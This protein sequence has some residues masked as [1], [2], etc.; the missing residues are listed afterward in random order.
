[1]IDASLNEVES[2]AA[3]AA[4]GA[5]LPWG[6]AEET[7]RAA[8]W[9][10]ACDE[11]WA[12]S[13]FDLLSRHMTFGHPIA[14]AG[15]LTSATA[16]LPMSPL[17]LGP[18][19]ADRGPCDQPLQLSLVAHPAWLLPFAGQV[20]AAGGTAIEILIARPTKAPVV[21]IAWPHAVEVTHEPWRALDDA[22]VVMWAPVRPSSRAGSPTFPLPRTQRSAVNE[23]D[24]AALEH[25]GARTY[26]PASTQSRE[27]GAGAG[28]VDND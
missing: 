6:L 9:L 22:E 17:V 11:P 20:A 27:Q 5:G 10:A 3:K 1:V 16:D 2:L 19:L 18:F 26:V 12:G 15:G 7:G 21:L 23:L 13:L 24:W 8:R 4:R 25:L 14:T 28:L